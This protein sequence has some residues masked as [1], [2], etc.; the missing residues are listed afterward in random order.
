MNWVKA[1]R[2]LG[3]FLAGT[4]GSWVLWCKPGGPLTASISLRDSYSFSSVLAGRKSASFPGCTLLFQG[5]GHSASGLGC[6][7]KGT[8]RKHEPGLQAMVTWKNQAKAAGGERGSK[9]C[10]E[11]QQCREVTESQR[12]WGL[13]RLG[14]DLS[15]VPRGFPH[16]NS[17]QS[18]I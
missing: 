6:T 10:H 12:T 5:E 4:R 1:R 3:P 7:G 18:G 9:V 13:E 17:S 14:G 15:Q 8:H 16:L 11:G 2:A